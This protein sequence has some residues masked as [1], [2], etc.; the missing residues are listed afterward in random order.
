V[1][2]IL[3]TVPVRVARTEDLS[4]DATASTAPV[5]KAACSAVVGPLW[6]DALAAERGAAASTLQTDRDDL[7]TAALRLTADAQ[8]ERLTARYDPEQTY[9]RPLIVARPDAL[10]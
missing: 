8:L 2:L 7:A 4:S 1:I 5:R 6:L 3:L 10:V 9:S